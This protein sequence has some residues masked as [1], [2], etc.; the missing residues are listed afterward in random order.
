[1]ILKIQLH[2]YPIFNLF[3]GFVFCQNT[4]M[5]EFAL[6]KLDNDRKIHNTIIY[7]INEMREK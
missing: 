6:F 7:Y 4:Q 3:L 5:N 2:H 1:M